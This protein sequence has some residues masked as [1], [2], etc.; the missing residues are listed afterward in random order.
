MD[1]AE[2]TAQRIAI[3]D[4]GSIVAQG[5]AQEL[6]T[7]TGADSLEDAFLKLTGTAIRDEASTGADQMRQFA[8]M[9]SGNR[10]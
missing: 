1:E 10:R 2:K 8:K 5:S 9:W 3:I 6:K 7:Q 4:H